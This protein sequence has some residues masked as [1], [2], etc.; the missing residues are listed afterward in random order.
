MPESP[1]LPAV[2]SRAWWRWINWLALDA[3]AVG[4]AWLFVFGRMTG[5][6]IEGVEAV[7]LLV[8]A[9]LVASTNTE[10]SPAASRNDAASEASTNLPWSRLS[11]IGRP[12]PSYSEG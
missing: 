5:A 3:V 9:G 12:Q 11:I 6:R 7:C 1:P 2:P 8:T 4:T 10:R